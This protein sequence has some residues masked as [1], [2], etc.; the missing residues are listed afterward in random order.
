MHVPLNAGQVIA[1]ET[2]SKLIFEPSNLSA[3]FIKVRQR[4]K[5]IVNGFSLATFETVSAR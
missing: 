2:V 4:E 1:A 5:W 3:H